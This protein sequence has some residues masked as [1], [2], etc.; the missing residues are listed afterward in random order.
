[1]STIITRKVY[2]LLDPGLHNAV[3]S[4]VDD[5][6]VK[7]TQY[8]PRDQVRIIF[9]SKDQVNKEGKPVDTQMTIN[10]SLD[11]RSRLGNLLSTLEI[12]PGDTFDSAE[13][14]GRK[15]QIVIKHV[16]GRD[17][18]KFA[19][20]ENVLNLKGRVSPKPVQQL[21]DENF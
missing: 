2:D 17:G 16:V 5:V 14:V 3:I 8:G 20:V 6:G 1:M 15:V 10:K 18:R 12:V 9:E 21:P 13:L 4:R 11:H 7:E 19:N